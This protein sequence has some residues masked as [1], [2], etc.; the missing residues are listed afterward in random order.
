MLRENFS[1][2]IVQLR[3]ELG[4]NQAELGSVVGVSPDA[5]SSWE[6]GKRF[7]TL[8]VLVALAD[9]FNVNL[10][11]LTGRSNVRDLTLAEKLNLSD[12]AIENLIAKV[13]H[14][15]TDIEA[16][17]AQYRQ[18]VDKILSS[19][20][21]IRLACLLADYA[22]TDKDVTDADRVDDDEKLFLNSNYLTKDAKIDLAELR[23]NRQW[24][25]LVN[26]VD[27]K[28]RTSAPT[29][30]TQESDPLHQ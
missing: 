26:D 13:R 25:A 20:E 30:A 7:A 12:K 3:Q 23:L 16:D 10:D 21:F 5:V 4:I 18:C 8:E 17:T 9:Y 19:E 14:C 15:S 27:T 2:R 1:S 24:Q 28:W 6:R 11:Y 22:N 29:E